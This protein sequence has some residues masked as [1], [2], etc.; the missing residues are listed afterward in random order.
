MGAVATYVF[1]KYLQAP[2]MRWA[3]AA[4]LALGLAL[5]SK[6]S[7]LLL[8]LVWPLQWVWYSAGA[9]RWVRKERVSGLPLTGLARKILRQAQVI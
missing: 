9:G 7:M 4:G 8:L 2:K 3:V 1:W 5:L 6:F